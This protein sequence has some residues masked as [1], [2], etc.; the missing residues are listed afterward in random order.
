MWNAIGSVIFESQSRLPQVDKSA[1]QYCAAEG[2]RIPTSVLEVDWNGTSLPAP[3][4]VWKCLPTVLF[5]DTF[6]QPRK[7]YIPIF[8]VI[9]WKMDFFSCQSLK[10]VICSSDG[11]LREI[12][13]FSDC[14][15]HKRIEIS[16]SVEIIGSRTRLSI[17]VCSQPD[18]MFID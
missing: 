8:V 3:D 17:G 7:L 13:G 1:F 15:S 9:I 10:Q 18:V 14:S 2:L 4:F 11:K 16:S 12:Y 5:F 6:T